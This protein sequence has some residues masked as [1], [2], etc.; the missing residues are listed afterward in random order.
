MGRTSPWGELAHP[1]YLLNLPSDPFSQRR[2]KKRGELVSQDDEPNFP[3]VID[4]V[5]S[6]S[7]STFVEDL[8]QPASSDSY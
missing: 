4:G 3:A 8:S 2:K 5:L 1:T 7:M 6:L